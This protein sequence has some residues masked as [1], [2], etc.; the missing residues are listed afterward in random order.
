MT[1]P[2]KISESFINEL[3]ILLE[4]GINSEIIYTLNQS[5]KKRYDN[6]N[7]IQKNKI[8]VGIKKENIIISKTNPD[9][10]KLDVGPSQISEKLKEMIVKN[11]NLDDM[12]GTIFYENKK[13]NFDEILNEQNLTIFYS[14]EYLDQLSNNE[15]SFLEDSKIKE[16]L[17]QSVEVENL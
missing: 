16:E 15:I 10:V 1:L 6:L 3:K 4:S 8:I 14:K 2:T 11:Y 9:E 5:L 17:L 7:P 13:I 12:T